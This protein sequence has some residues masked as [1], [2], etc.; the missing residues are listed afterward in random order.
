MGESEREKQR[1][2]LRQSHSEWETLQRLSNQ[3]FLASDP[4]KRQKNPPYDCGRS[5][6]EN[7]NRGTAAAEKQILRKTRETEVKLDLAE[8][9]FRYNLLCCFNQDSSMR[10]QTGV[11]I[12]NLPIAPE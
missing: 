10:R 2:R 7:S 6:E 4:L 11:Q 5:L 3:L 1:P 12:K 8:K 9:L